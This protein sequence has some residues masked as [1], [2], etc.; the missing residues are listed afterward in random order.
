MTKR[1]YVVTSNYDES[2]SGLL[3]VSDEDPENIKLKRCAQL[4]WHRL[5]PSFLMFLNKHEQL[6]FTH[7]ESL[8]IR[9]KYPNL[10]EDYQDLV[11]RL[12]DDL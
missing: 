5:R 8:V 11:R 12:V 10:Y 2:G 4:R 1:F 3:E 9:D 7:L 6:T